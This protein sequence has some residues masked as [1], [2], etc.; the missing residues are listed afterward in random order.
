MKAIKLIIYCFGFG[1]LNAVLAFVRI[2]QVC[3]NALSRAF[4][5]KPVIGFPNA[6]L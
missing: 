6:A 5:I 4:K 1:F 3:P 2:G